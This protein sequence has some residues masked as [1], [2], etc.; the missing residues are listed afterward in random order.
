MRRKPKQNSIAEILKMN[1]GKSNQ[2]Q[3]FGGPLPP[4]DDPRGGIDDD[5][6]R[7]DPLQEIKDKIR[8]SEPLSVSCN[9][10]IYYLTINI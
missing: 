3:S 7:E 2:L 6:I 8:V 5:I 1:R 9:H 10:K 4:N